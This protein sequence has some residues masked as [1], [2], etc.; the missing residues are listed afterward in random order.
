M[1]G[2]D[3]IDI[4]RVRASGAQVS[5]GRTVADYATH[6]AGFPEPFF[7]RLAE[8]G[9]LRAGQVALDI[10]TGT[11]TVARGLALRGARV[12]AVDPSRTLMEQAAEQDASAGVRVAYQ[13]A[14]AEALPF[15]DGRFDLAV[16]GQCWHWFDRDAAAAEAARVLRPGGTLVIAHFDWLPLAGN[17][18]A[19][20]EAL[21]LRYNPTWAMGGG[22]GFYPQ[23][24]ADL[25]GAGFKDLQSFSFDVTQ[26]YTPEAWRG[27]IRASAGVAASLSAGDVSRFDAE[28]ARMLAEDFPG[29]LLHVPHRVWAILGTRV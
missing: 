10:G 28:L 3:G 24:A 25:S 5:F 6:R 16:A 8:Q 4:A 13:E 15:D 20:T 29:D 11:G 22:T 17:L 18:V 19:A 23:W 9:I 7:D 12:S 26:P 2:D 27:R 1:S 14:R 21:I